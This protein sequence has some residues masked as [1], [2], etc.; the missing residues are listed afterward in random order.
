MIGDDMTKLSI[1]IFLIITICFSLSYSVTGDVIHIVTHD[2]ELAITDPSKGENLYPRTAL[3]P[4]VDTEYR[5]AVLNITYACPDSLHCGEWDYID[6]V[7]LRLFDY[8]GADTL[9][10]EIARMISPYGWW[11]DSL[12]SFS[13]DIDITEFAPLLHDS[14]EIIFRHSGYESNEDRGWLV[15]IDFELTEGRPSVKML[16]FDTLWCGSFKYGDTADPFEGYFAPVLLKHKEAMLAKMRIVQ[17]GHGMD[18]YENCAEF[19]EKYRMIFLDSQLIDFREIWKQCGDNPLY[20]QAG[21]WIFDRANW[22]PGQIVDPD[23]Y[24]FEITPDSSREL[25]IDMEPYTNPNKPTANYSISSYIFYYDKPWARNDVSIEKIIIPNDDDESSRINPSCRNPQIII[26]NQGSDSLTS[27]TIN[28]GTD[29]EMNSY[30]WN[31]KLSTQDMTQIT[32]PGA[33]ND[34]SGKQVFSVALEKPNGEDDEYIYDNRMTSTVVIPPL[35]NNQFIMVMKTN[36]QAEENSY[37]LID[38]DGRIINGRELGTLMPDSIY[39][40]TFNLMPDCYQLIVSD[41]GGDGLKFWFNTEAGYGYARL[42]DMDGKLIKNFN[43]DFGSSI[44]FTFTATEDAPNNYPTDSLPLVQAFPT[45]SSGETSLYL[46]FNDPTDIEIKIS[47]DSTG[48]VVYEQKEAGV[49]DA[50]FPIN[51][52]GNDEGVYNIEILFDDRTV[53]KR[54]RLRK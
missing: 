48:A 9:D 34:L 52:E 54:F 26:K 20:P 13:W 41:T 45:R 15:T 2:K 47:N 53:K 40:D 5:K 6:N 18:D 27:L 14:V 22:C 33:I 12:W 46:F 3:F 44:N 7:Y 32:L 36:K 28:Y 39:T 37:R 29:D 31:G 24:T 8:K 43:S 4:S 19:C 51:I 21:T 30:H 23:I 50:I 42:L 35:F 16:D 11:F 1:L 10:I 38:K 17:T 49:K 25:N